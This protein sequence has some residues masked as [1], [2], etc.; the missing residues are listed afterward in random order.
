M[1]LMSF[2]V[3]VFFASLF[4]QENLWFAWEEKQYVRLYKKY[5]KDFAKIARSLG[6]DIKACIKYYYVNKKRLNLQER[7]PRPPRLE[8]QRDGMRQRERER[9]LI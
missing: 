4:R 5:R 3:L 8:I 2:L 7:P 9:V 6:K 1:A